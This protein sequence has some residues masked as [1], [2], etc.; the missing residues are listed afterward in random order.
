MIPKEIPIKILEK[1][2][3]GFSEEFFTK[4][5]EE[6]FK[7]IHKEFLIDFTWRNLQKTT[8]IIPTISAEIPPK[9]P[10]VIDGN[11][12]GHSVSENSSR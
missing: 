7:E 11:L 1:F 2:F 8:P 10:L 9:N 4:F 3:N 5:L 6:S 12:W